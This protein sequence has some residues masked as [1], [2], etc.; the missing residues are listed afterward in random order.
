MGCYVSLLA[1]LSGE[2]A[3]AMSTLTGDGWLPSVGGTFSLAFSQRLDVMYSKTTE[4][5]PL[6]GGSIHHHQ[7]ITKL[8]AFSDGIL[9]E[10]KVWP[11][12]LR[13]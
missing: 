12:S 9:N 7:V 2:E 8:Y 5:C 11:P 4:R 1:L 6:I 13:S 10:P 3:Y